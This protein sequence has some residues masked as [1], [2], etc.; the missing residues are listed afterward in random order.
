MPRP[1]A[2]EAVT[3]FAPDFILL[4]LGVSS[5]QLDS[6]GRGFSFRPGVALDMRMGASGATAADLL[7]ELP[8][9]ELVAILRDYADERKAGA[10]AREIVR[11]RE[12]A[13]FRVE[14]RPGQHHPR[15]AGRA[16]GPGRICPDLPGVPDRGE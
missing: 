16:G 2:L 13:P 8:E 9:G 4:D 6:D 11:R 15:R 10:M 12:R 1:A 14:R 5:R 7:N 3:A